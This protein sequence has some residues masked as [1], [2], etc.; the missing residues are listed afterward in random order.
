MA[1]NMANGPWQEPETTIYRGMA[2]GGTGGELSA[3]D[4]KNGKVVRIRPIRYT[5]EYTMD[6]LKDSLWSFTVRGKT[7][8]C[9]VKTAPP[10]QSLAYKK[11]IYSNNRVKYP[12]KRVDWE[13]GGDPEK[14][15]PENRGRSKFVR[16]S[17]DEAC[18]IM[19]SEVKRIRETYGENAVLAV[20][21]DGHCQSKLIHMVG[22]NHMNFLMRTGGWT[23]EVRTPDSVEGF[24]WGAK[25][26]WGAQ[27]QAGLAMFDAGWN[28]LK[29]VCENAEMVV[30]QA[31]DLETTQNYSAQWMSRAMRFMMDTGVKMVVVDPFCT[32]TSVCHD[33]ITWI[34]LLP[35]TDVALDYGIMYVWLTENLYDA[36]YVA[37]HTTGFE[38]LKAYILGE[39]DGIPKDPKW[40]SERCGTEPWT[41]KALAREWG[42]KATT[43]LHYCG[44]HVRG[45]Y[46]HEPGRTEVYKLALQGFGA[47]G[48]QQMHLFTY[49]GAKQKTRATCSGPFLFSEMHALQFYPADQTIPRTLIAKSI[50]DG[51]SQWWGSPQIIFATRDEQFEEFRY[52]IPEDEGG[53]EVHML[54]SEK[55]CNETCWGGGF[56]FQNAMRNPKLECVVTN[57]PWLENDSLFADLVLPVTTPVE[58]ADVVGSGMGDSIEVAAVQDAA[59]PPV[60]ES[61]SDYQISLEIAKRYGGQELADQMA[62]GMIDGQPAVGL[63]IEQQQRSEFERSKVAKEISWEEFREKGFYI[64][65]LQKNWDK[66]KPNARLFY[67]DPENFPMDTESGLIEFYSQELADGFP[68]DKER[69]PL[70]KW[71]EGGS[72]EDGW[73]HDETLRGERA[74]KYPFLVNA[75]TGRWRF[76]AQCDDITWHREISTAKVVGKDGYLYEPCWLCPEDAEKLG[77]VDGDIVKVFNERGT[78]LAGAKVSER[79][80]PQSVMV[81]KGSRSDPIAPNFDRGGNINLISPAGPISKH[82]YGFVVS[83]YLVAVE[84]VTDAEMEQWKQ[85]YPEA[86]ERAYDPASGSHYAGWVE[87]VE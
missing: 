58:E 77:I 37:T 60:G 41:I 1:E 24:Y 19:A 79:I 62:A 64:P 40:A 15:H 54:W 67:D 34:P 38:Q 45:P 7:L 14:I 87:G 82:C 28:V 84:K 18:D 16:I 33:E 50:E 35:N 75:C 11:R 30:M 71:V 26:V 74:K 59:I 65:K 4:S 63:T 85:E 61:L 31:G 72:E 9:P 51:H 13:P 56:A 49:G 20:G 78:V 5:D 81:C 48:V 17:W 23:R 66:I 55:P 68:E 80:L 22:G 6:E 42:K 27:V 25:F 36:D 47:P 86:F 76:H 2:C 53:C 32:Y 52:P 57:H 8:S 29:D 69:G 10:Y 44:C 39:E 46:S 21:E 73:S 12:L 3:V 83:G 70:A 43:I